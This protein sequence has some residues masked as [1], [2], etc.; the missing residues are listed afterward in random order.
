MRHVNHQQ[1]AYFI[2]DFAHAG[3]VP[4]AAVGRTATDDEFGL[5]LVR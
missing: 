1:S 2:G 3:I 4:L 5:V